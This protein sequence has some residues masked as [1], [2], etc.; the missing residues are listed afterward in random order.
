MATKLTKPKAEIEELFNR[1][2]GRGQGLYGGISVAESEQARNDAIGELEEWDRSAQ[3]LLVRAFTDPPT[4]VYR[5]SL[6]KESLTDTRSYKRD[7][8]R[9][10][11][12]FKVR[13]TALESIRDTLDLYEEPSDVISPR[14]ERSTL[15]SRVFIGHGRSLV[16]RELKD[17]VADQLDLPWDEFNR[18]PVAGMA[19]IDRLQQMLDEAAVAFLV[20]TAE[21][22]QA[23]GKLKA[24]QNVV[25]EAGLFQGRLGFKRAI[26]MLEEG[27]EEFSNI[28]G[29]SQLRFRAGDIRAEFQSVREVLEREGLI[30]NHDE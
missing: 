23:D 4:N 13:L 6:H 15:G 1:V 9:I 29:L 12:E 3:E 14:P 5:P 21:D 28:Y 17:F 19:T 27:C 18:V 7:I 10:K 30:P 26:L 8:E 22:E 20:L 2:I 25:H 11:N 16:W 24:R